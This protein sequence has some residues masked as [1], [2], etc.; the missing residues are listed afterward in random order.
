MLLG[1][2][3]HMYICNKA[4][5]LQVSMSYISTRVSRLVLTRDTV[6][7]RSGQHHPQ[8][9]NLD[10]LADFYQK[11]VVIMAPTSPT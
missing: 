7:R 4:F 1:I 2:V 3:C 8:A 5:L 10:E 11:Q 9:A 6:G